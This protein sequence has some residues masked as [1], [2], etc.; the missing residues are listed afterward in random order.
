MNEAESDI[1]H[2]ISYLYSLNGHQS[3]KDFFEEKAYICSCPSLMK[4]IEFEE[5]CFYIKYMEHCRI[6]NYKFYRQDRG[7]IFIKLSSGKIVCI[8][9][10]LQR[11]I[12]YLT[13]VHIKHNITENE[14]IKINK[15][16]S[17][18]DEHQQNILKTFIARTP[19]DGYLSFK[20]DGS[21]SGIN[22]YPKNSEIYNVIS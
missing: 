15:D 2:L 17:Y 19:I 4:K 16:L 20:N 22:F 1:T 6:F 7:S 9:N 21:L 18:L 5:K 3:V 10:L 8:K 13:G 14:N 12:E 11:E